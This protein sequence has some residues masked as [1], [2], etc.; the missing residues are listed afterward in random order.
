MQVFSKI[1]DLTQLYPK[2][3]MA[4]GTFDG[5]HVGHQSIIRQAIALAASIHGISVVFT[6]SNHPL[7]VIA[8]DKAPLQIGDTISKENILAELGVDILVNIPFTRKFAK[9]LPDQFLTTLQENFAPSYIVVGPNFSFGYRGKGNPRMLLRE[10]P[11]YGFKAEIASAVQWN[12][13][14]VSST[15]IRE[16]LMKGDLDLA[17][18]FLGRP[19]SFGGRVVHGDRRGRLLGFPTANLAIADD[20]AMLP[21][22]VYAVWATLQ[23][24][25]YEGI[26]NIG[27]NPTFEGCN[28]RLEV[29]ILD[30]SGDIYDAALQVQFLKKIRDEQKF[31]SAEHLVHQLHEDKAAARTLFHVYQ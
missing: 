24:K 5:V 3:V 29:H 31:P 22:G 6:F 11:S 19:F 23:G 10:G 27:T 28:R 14:T 13:H 30:F 16:L 20:R 15:R 26:A 1:M 21:N 7:S 17:N 4:L 25:R 2:I 9:V 18:E 8:P 12:G